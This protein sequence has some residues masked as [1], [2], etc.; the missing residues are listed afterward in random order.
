MPN[1]DLEMLTYLQLADLSQRKRQT[2][3]SDKLLVLAGVA[4]CKAGCLPVAARCREIV[5]QHH[6]RHLLARYSSFADALRSDEFAP[7][8]KR[9]QKLCSFEAAEFLAREWRVFDDSAVDR[10]A[11]EIESAALEL[12]AAMS[13]RRE[14]R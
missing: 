11:T 3:G 8:L 6:P 7:L 10:D 1:H 2:L 9:L 13:A 4:A 5:I 12:L 14:P